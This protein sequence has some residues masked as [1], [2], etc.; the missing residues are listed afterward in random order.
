LVAVI[1]TGLA[2]VIAGTVG[3]TKDDT[4][5]VFVNATLNPPPSLDNSG[6]CTVMSAQIA[7]DANNGFYPL[8]EVTVF[9]EVGNCI[10]EGYNSEDSNATVF[11]VN[12]IIETT[13]DLL[14]C[15][16]IN[17]TT[18]GVIDPN[19]S[20]CLEN[21]TV[22]NNVTNFVNNHSVTVDKPCSFN[23][24]FLS[25]ATAAVSLQPTGDYT[26]NRIDYSSSTIAAHY[27]SSYNPSG[28]HAAEVSI[29]TTIIGIIAIPVIMI[30][31]AGSITLCL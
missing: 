3:M 4:S 11:S 31:I 14:N 8:F 24:D 21:G 13:S 1:I 26:S 5:Y 2:L 25:G 7:G 17:V 18:Q 15:T 9:P 23:I 22:C 30:I 28:S 6:L 12:C 20:S 19:F 29:G 27:S 16:A 10:C